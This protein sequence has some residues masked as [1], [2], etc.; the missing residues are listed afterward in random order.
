MERFECKKYEW[1]KVDKTKCDGCGDCVQYCPRD[2]L[3]L[4]NQGR[5]YM[6][7]RGVCWDCEVCT[8]MGQLDA[9]RVEPVPVLLK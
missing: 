9:S 8:S 2:V 1:V 4:D 6:A 3:R 5:P 7:Y